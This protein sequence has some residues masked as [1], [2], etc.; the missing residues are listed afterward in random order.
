MNLIMALSLAAGLLAGALALWLGL[1]ARDAPVPAAASRPAVT[2]R[3][4]WRQA[5]S[6]M[7]G[8]LRALR[9]ALGIARSDR[10][11]QPWVILLGES[12]A[13]K[14][15]VVAS[16]AWVQQR[17]QARATTRPG[18]P[19]TAWHEL[20]QGLLIDVDGRLSDADP[21]TPLA[22]DWLE[23][24]RGIL[25]QRPERALDGVML[26][27]S[28]HTLAGR[29]AQARLR[30]ARAARR[31]LTD[32]RAQLDLVLPVYVVVTR[33]DALPGFG[34]YWRA[35]P[36]EMHG[37]MQGASMADGQAQ[38][39]PAG[40]LDA[41]WAALVLRLE[42]LQVEAAA[43]QPAIAQADDF[44]LYPRHFEQ[45][46]SGAL[47]FLAELFSDAAW[48]EAFLC[49]GI[50]FTGNLRAAAQAPQGPRS[51][52]A[53][54]DGL[55][56]GK[57]LAERGL[58]RITRQSIWSRDR[59]LLALQRGAVA[60]A[61]LTTAAL[62]L[63]AVRLD[64]DVAAL[65]QSIRQLRQSQAVQSSGGA[66]I[67]KPAVDAALTQAAAIEASLAHAA[68]PL[69]WIDRRAER[70]AV[71]EVSDS[72]LART[73]FPA[74][75]CALQQR[76]QV[77]HAALPQ[78]AEATLAGFTVIGSDYA[79]V[80]VTVQAQARAVQALEESL[81]RFERLVAVQ[82][83]PPQAKLQ[84]LEQLSLYA[85]GSGLPKPALQGRGIIE[86]AL[87][88]VPYAAGIALPGRMRLTFAE[89][90][91]SLTRELH[92]QLLNEVRAGPS[93]Q[94]RLE[95][96]PSRT[97]LRATAPVDS[98]RR[99]TAWLTWVSKSW[100]PSDPNNNPCAN[101]AAHLGMLLRPLVDNHGYPP[102]LLAYL[103]S[104][105]PHACYE[106]ALAV[107]RAMKIAPYGPLAI[108][109]GPTLLLNPDLNGEVRGFTAL[110]TQT[111]MQLARPR[112]LA[113]VG[114]APGWRTVD[115]GR[116][117]SYAREFQQFTASQSLAPL[118]AAPARQP[119][120]WRVGQWQLELAMND[121]MVAAQSAAGA[122]EIVQGLDAVSAADQQ[123]LEQ[124]GEFSRALQP[125]L[126]VLRLYTQMGFNRSRG[127]VSQCARDFASGVLART[128]SLADQ[129]RL[130]APEAG[131]PDGPLVDLGTTSVTRD[132]LARQLARAQVLAGYADPFAALLRNTDGVSD[133]QQGNTASLPYWTN[134]INQLNAYVQF[135]DSSGQV[136]DLDT[137][138][139]KTI[140]GLSYA[141]CGKQLAGLQPDDYGNDLFSS[142]RR[143]LVAWLG[144]LCFDR[145]ATVA[146]DAYQRLANRFNT[147]LAGAYPFGPLEGSQEASLATAKAFFLDYDANRAALQSSL[148]GV[149]ATRWK[150]QLEFIAQLDKAAAFLRGSLTA[151]PASQPIRLQ[152]TFRAQASVP[153]GAPTTAASLASQVV[154]WTL[155]AGP[156]VISYPGLNPPVIDWPYGQALE[157]TLNWADRSVWRPVQS[158]SGGTGASFA[159]GGNWALLRLL[160]RHRPRYAASV[161]P[162]DPTRALVELVV[163]VV[164]ID[165]E[166]ANATPSTALFYLG[167]N[168]SAN[169]GKAPTPVALTWPGP[170]PR[171]AP[172][173][174]AAAKTPSTSR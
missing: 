50:Y 87:A 101:N 164:R 156:R 127:V 54:V 29:D 94:A 92:V 75:S 125:M 74:L 103:P 129:S 49:R 22:A 144:A 128:S 170:F 20:P 86:E 19:M 82:A 149:D 16:L 77:L 18:V 98:A 124:S 151:T 58:A 80:L 108:A 5:W 6:R 93:L 165:V 123:L 111:Y 134:T 139:L 90:L 56:H 27:V 71:R 67:A 44:F 167:L 10:Y 83:D 76:A 119:L 166:P 69:S 46:R 34:A 118:G 162:A 150:T 147:E 12:G 72:V 81:Q 15:S 137:L 142:R 48:D 31:Q 173:A 25:A 135:K 40:W 141:N 84:L 131:P 9:V 158:Q 168:L 17:P 41:A 171:F 85:F 113:C 97:D 107:L 130:Y 68:M 109:S 102:A 106:P 1:R 126:G 153:V 120:Y 66:C 136:G 47:Q 14:S 122:P 8:W 42:S 13:G 26:A 55:V 89:R 132:Y 160:Q 157:L 3:F 43:V 2:A 57:V 78:P 146:S 7:L 174:P 4:G 24:L 104:F 140:A 133:A 112:P 21:G 30:V 70:A 159:S 64:R 169:D 39:P 114:S 59:S 161:D 52:V 88:D 63:A 155:A 117:E 53:F 95:T 32:L 105:G 38:P 61:V 36:P 11:R 96:D 62:A 121:A 99:F 116:A 23:A 138:F 172:A 79:R 35:F 28:A 148:A 145:Q 110:L 37:Q 152:V 154:G 45:L 65:D 163:P 60:A 143:S 51:D 73:V 91:Q 100:L 115:I 33:C